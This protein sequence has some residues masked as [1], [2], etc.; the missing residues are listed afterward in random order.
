LTPAQQRGLWVTLPL[1]APYG[2]RVEQARDQIDEVARAGVNVD[3]LTAAVT[4]KE[5][6]ALT[7]DE[8]LRVASAAGEIHAGRAVLVEENGMPLLTIPQQPS[9]FS[10]EGGYGPG[11][12]SG[13]NQ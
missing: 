4:G 2:A 12:H 11:R 9:M 7:G 5:W 13:R 6:G 10:G 3:Q 8:I 1:A